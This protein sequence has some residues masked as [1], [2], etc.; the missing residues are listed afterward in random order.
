MGKESNHSNKNNKKMAKEWF[1]IADNDIRFAKAAFEEFDDFYSHICIQAHQAT[2]KYLKGFLIFHKKD[3]PKIHDLSYF[4]KQCAKIDK[5]FNE[6]LDFCKKITDYYIYLRYPVTLPPRTKT[7][8]KEAI[9]I[10]ETIGK[11][12]KIKIGILNG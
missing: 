12:V 9:E 10:A 8:A 6:Y 11:L 2:E 4:V 7:E 5:G 3:F 1:A